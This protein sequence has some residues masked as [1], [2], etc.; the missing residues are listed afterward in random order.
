MKKLLM[1]LTLLSSSAL[2]AQPAD[3][4]SMLLTGT[5]LSYTTKATFPDTPQDKDFKFFADE[6]PAGPQKVCGMS[7][8]PDH[9]SGALRISAASFSS[10]KPMLAHLPHPKAPNLLTIENGSGSGEHY[11]LEFDPSRRTLA[12]R[13]TSTTVSQVV[14]GVKIDNG[15]LKALY[16]GGKT[17]ALTYPTTAKK[18]DIY[19]KNGSSTGYLEWQQVSFDL[20]SPT[21]SIYEK[22]S[23]PAK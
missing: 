19:V 2:A 6:N 13:A 12:Y 15:P 23:M 10:F 9:K 17:T 7:F 8:V 21:I 16:F 1:T 11:A 14:A 22:A 18:L 4:H 3:C 5:W 20:K